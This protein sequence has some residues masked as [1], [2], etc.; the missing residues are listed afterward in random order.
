MESSFL[1]D[2]HVMLWWLGDPARLSGKVRELLGKPSTEIY[3]SA[4][5]AF[6]ISRKNALGKLP[7]PEGFLNQYKK[8]MM[9]QQWQ[10]LP[11]STTHSLQAGGYQQAHKDPFDRLLAAQAET[12]PLVLITSDEAFKSFN[13]QTLW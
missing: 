12:E 5:S 8:T 11:V 3:Y 7:L 9:N 10:E 4:I 1:L 6:E 13:I 2:T